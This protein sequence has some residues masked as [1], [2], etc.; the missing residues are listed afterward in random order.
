MS[1]HDLFLFFDCGKSCHRCGLRTFPSFGCPLLFG[2][3]YTPNPHT[4]AN[5]LS[6]VCRPCCGSPIDVLQ[7]EGPKLDTDKFYYTP[8]LSD[9]PVYDA[10][11]C[12][13]TLLGDASMVS[14]LDLTH[15]EAYALAIV[16]LYCDHRKEQK[17]KAIPNHKKTSLCRPEWKKERL[18]NLIF[19][20]RGVRPPILGCWRITQP[21]HVI[22]LD[23]TRSWQV[24]R[25]IVSIS[26]LPIC[27]CTSMALKLLYDR[28]Y[29]LGRVSATRTLPS[30]CYV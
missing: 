25:R 26:L 5:S 13:F 24:M 2:D 30:D 14:L 19:P 6:H 8:Q 12:V 7:S 20:L 17:G 9:W 28:A 21:M 29:I 22:Y 27:F 11:N 18:C 23:I 15:D 3:A 16:K 10:V 4:K 1:E